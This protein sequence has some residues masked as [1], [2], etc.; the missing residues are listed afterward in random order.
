MIMYF[1]RTPLAL[2]AP[3][4]P[5]AQLSAPPPR[6]G[7]HYSE[8]PRGIRTCAGCRRERSVGGINCAESADGRWRRAAGPLRSA[9][10]GS[11]RS[12]TRVRAA[13]HRNPEDAADVMAETFLTSWRRL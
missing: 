5:L 3:L 8:M 6:T 4:A 9:V 10:P 11:P 7:H 13:P 2:G 1:T 12:G